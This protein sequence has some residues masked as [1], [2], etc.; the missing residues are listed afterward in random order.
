M[1]CLDVLTRG[2]DETGRPGGQLK[3][4]TEQSRFRRAAGEIAETIQEHVRQARDGNF[5]WC[6]PGEPVAGL[7]PT[8]LGAHLFSG[9][10]GVAFFLATYSW[11]AK[12]EDSG[13]LALKSLA[14]LR[15]EIHELAGDPEKARGLRHS[16]G[17]L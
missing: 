6:H 5:Y 2:V 15:R 13:G 4:T 14:P 7:R 3:E 12:D 8:P 16:I 1:G 10:V 17:G 9:S 11:I